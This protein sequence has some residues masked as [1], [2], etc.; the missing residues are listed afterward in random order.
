MAWQRRQAKG[1]DGIADLWSCVDAAAITPFLV[2]AG[3]GSELVGARTGTHAMT[4]EKKNSFHTTVR[5]LLSLQARTR[6]LGRL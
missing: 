2:A 4:H 3:T 1:F 5:H 6:R